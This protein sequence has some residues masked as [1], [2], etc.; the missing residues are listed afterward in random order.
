MTALQIRPK[1]K[2]SNQSHT[3]L[4][5]LR[6]IGKDLIYDLCDSEKRCKHILVFVCNLSKFV[7]VRTLNSKS[8]KGATQSLKDVYN[9][10]RL[11]DIIMPDQ[12]SQIL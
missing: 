4:K 1:K 10:M 6:Q 9:E 3:K 8:S 7:A 2:T 12:G 11:P 5:R